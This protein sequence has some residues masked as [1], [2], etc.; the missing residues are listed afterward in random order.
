[1]CIVGGGFSD[2]VR[3]FGSRSGLETTPP[4]SSLR[5]RFEEGFG[6]GSSENMN[7]SILSSSVPVRRS[8]LNRSGASLLGGGGSR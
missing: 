2:R 3:T 4:I 5:Q 7:S 1:M 8:N 6:R